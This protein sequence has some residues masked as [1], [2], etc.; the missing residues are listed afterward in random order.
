[1][2]EAGKC[3]FVEAFN[4]RSNLVNAHSFKWMFLPMPSLEQSNARAAVALEM[5]LAWTSF[6]LQKKIFNR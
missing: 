4:G 2:D 3:S 1:M 6:Y 5:S